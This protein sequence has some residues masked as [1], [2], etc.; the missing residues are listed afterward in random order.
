MSARWMMPLWVVV[1]AVFVVG[2][3]LGIAA[4]AKSWQLSHA[5]RGLIFSGAGYVTFMLLP[6][7]FG[8][9]FTRLTSRLIGGGWGTGPTK[10]VLLGAAVLVLGFLGL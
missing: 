3:L 4:V 5:A 6:L 1:T 7:A 8:F 10:L 9:L 2:W